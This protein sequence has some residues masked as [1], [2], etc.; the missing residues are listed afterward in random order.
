MKAEV[1]KNAEILI[2]TRK[3]GI[4]SDAE[5]MRVIKE[6]GNISAKRIK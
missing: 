6:K 3:S 1:P 5:I 2:L 4:P